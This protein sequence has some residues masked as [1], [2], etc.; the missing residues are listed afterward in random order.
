MIVITIMVMRVVVVIRTGDRGTHS[1]TR[2]TMIAAT[3][4]PILDLDR[5]VLDRK[6]QAFGEIML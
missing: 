3:A 1:T 6:A 4:R 5:V 2:L